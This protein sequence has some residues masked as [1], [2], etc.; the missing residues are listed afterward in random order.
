MFSYMI[1]YIIK[2]ET[3]KHCQ[4]Y[5]LEASMLENENQLKEQKVK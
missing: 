2:S 4:G 5:I 3:Q 1:Y